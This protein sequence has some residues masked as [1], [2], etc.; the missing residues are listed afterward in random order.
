MLRSCGCLIFVILATI[1]TGA[2]RWA[3]LR[4]NLIITSS[5]I[6][7]IPMKKPSVLRTLRHLKAMSIGFG[8]RFSLA[9]LLIKVNE[10]TCNETTEEYE[11]KDCDVHIHPKSNLPA[12]KRKNIEY[13]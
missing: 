3:D 2:A 8:F 11:T 6:L 9:L 4:L 13:E 12:C 7:T 5:H 10:A 1:I